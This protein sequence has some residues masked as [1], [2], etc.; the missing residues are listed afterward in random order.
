MCVDG[1]VLCAVETSWPRNSHTVCGDQ[2][3][4]PE[5]GSDLRLFWNI[6]DVLLSTVNMDVFLI[7]LI[8]SVEQIVLYSTRTYNHIILRSLLSSDT[9]SLRGIC[10]DDFFNANHKIERITLSLLLQGAVLP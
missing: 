4:N 6:V 2:C 5:K 1:L 7:F 10:G 8:S 3:V 9:S